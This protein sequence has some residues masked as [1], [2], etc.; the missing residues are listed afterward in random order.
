[1]RV[2]NLANLEALL[3][4]I[5]NMVE[6]AGLAVGATIIMHGILLRTPCGV[7]GI[8]QPLSPGT[9]ILIGIAIVVGA[10]MVPGL[11]NWFV[12]S[13]RDANLFS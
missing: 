6:L 11:V 12:A 5:T 4:I 13:A 3:N 1:V 2:N 9:R 8:A 10:C 7:L